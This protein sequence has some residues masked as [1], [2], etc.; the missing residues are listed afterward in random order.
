MDAF[1]VDLPHVYSTDQKV[2][3]PVPALMEEGSGYIKVV[4]VDPDRRTV[5]YRLRT[6]AGA[7]LATQVNRCHSILF[8]LSGAWEYEGGWVSPGEITYAVENTSHT[9]RSLPGMELLVVLRGHGDPLLVCRR[10]DGTTL[11]LDL[12]WF[13]ALGNVWT[14]AEAERFSVVPWW[15]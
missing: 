11:P 12:A 8:T 10:Q 14:E 5:I 4:H 13:Q 7:K 6:F 1:A 15:S 2:W 3:V 9:P